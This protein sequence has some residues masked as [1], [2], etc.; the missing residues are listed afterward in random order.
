MLEDV[1]K[2]YSDKDIRVHVLFDHP[3]EMLPF[4][5]DSLKPD[6]VVLGS[7]SHPVAERLLRTVS[8]YFIRAK[9]HPVEDVPFW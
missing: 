3:V 6:S 1:S 7:P 9:R 8:S 2:R 5:A 4:L